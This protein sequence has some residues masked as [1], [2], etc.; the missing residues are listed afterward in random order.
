MNNEKMVTLTKEIESKMIDT[1][2]D[3]YC[4]LK[5]SDLGKSI[6]GKTIIERML[7]AI[8]CFYGFLR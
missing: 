8:K 1:L 5:G 4:L 7:D 6:V 3:A 2:T